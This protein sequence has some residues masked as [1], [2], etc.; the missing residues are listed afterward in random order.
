VKTER[1]RLGTTVSP[2]AKSKPW[3]IARQTLALDHLSNGRFTLG[4]GLGIEETVDYARWDEDADPKVLA[5]KLDESLEIVTGLSTGKPF[6]FTGEHYKV[7]KKTRFL[8]G[9]KQRPR[10]PVWIAGYWPRKAP[11]RRAAQWDGVIPLRSPSKLASPQ[12][13]REIAAFINKVRTSKAHFDIANIG[14]TTGKNKRKDREKVESFREAG[15]TW[16]LESL[17]TKRDS[18]S[19]MLE[20]IKQGPPK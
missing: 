8:P 10:I 20:R 3:I 2:L 12:D 13:I 9:S 5:E 15:I 19:K 1:L 6:Q 14:W 4:V 18:P 7:K 16:W 11:F 17:Y